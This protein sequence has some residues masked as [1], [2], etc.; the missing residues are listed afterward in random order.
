MNQKAGVGFS[1]GRHYL[2]IAGIIL[3]MEGDPCRDGELPED[4]YDP[5]PEEELAGASI[6]GRQAS[7]LP[8]K[9]IRFFRG[10]RWTQ[11]MLE[12]VAATINGQE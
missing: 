8:M 6:G 5:I 3:A 12:Y 1:T 7:E 2:K 11:K 10:D 4:V 9:V